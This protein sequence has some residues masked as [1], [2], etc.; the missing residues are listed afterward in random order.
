[1]GV[2]YNTGNKNV[3]L[4]YDNRSKA[5]GPYTLVNMKDWWDIPMLA[6]SNKTERTGYPTQ[7]PLTLYER[8]INAS[9][10]KGDMVLDPF[11]GCA[12]TLVAAERLKRQWVGIDIWDKAHKTVITRLQK[13]GLETSDGS[14]SG[15]LPFG[16]IHYASK[17]PE[18]T[19]GGETI[20]PELQVKLRVKEPRGPKMSRAEM[21]EILLSTQGIKCQ[22]CYRIFD[23]HRYLELDH[24][25]PRADGGINHVSN[26][27]LLCSPCNRL[28]SNIY[29]L[30]GLRR[31]N[32]KR[33]YIAKGGTP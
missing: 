5:F 2:G 3:S 7:K 11:A 1:M 6:T 15:L 27:I 20:A 17:P 33:G 22:G 12:T 4:Y 30:S 13:E 9:S 31:E 23:D 29:T 14:L 32:H 28:K 25:T 10:N 21:Y 24:N 19:D 26:R 8:I 16:K 18:R